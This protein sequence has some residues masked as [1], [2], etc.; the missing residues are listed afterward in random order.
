MNVWDLWDRKAHQ[1]YALHARNSGAGRFTKYDTK[2][3]MN[4][5]ALYFGVCEWV[6]MNRDKFHPYYVEVQPY[7]D[8]EAQLGNGL[9]ATVGYTREN[10]YHEVCDDT[11]AIVE[12]LG[13]KSMLRR[14]GLMPERVMCRL[15]IQ[16][17]G[18]VIPWHCDTMQKWRDANQDIDP[19]LVTATKF[20]AMLAQDDEV[21]LGT[22]RLLSNTSFGLIA[23]RII[24][25][26]PWHPGHVYQVGNVFVPKW[27]SGDVFDARPA[28][29]HLTA[30]AG[31]RL[32]ISIIATSVEE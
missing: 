13:G 3:M 17:P 4:I 12:L 19:Q 5:G 21:T 6:N 14:M 7:H 30:N 27:K 32:R 18:S 31:I 23:R 10:T 16:P 24:M 11:P 9:P 20:A 15:Q 8:E 28:Q 22:A 29:W 25:V 2:P 26:T 1:P